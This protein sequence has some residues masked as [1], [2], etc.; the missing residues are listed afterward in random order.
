MKKVYINIG[1]HSVLF[2]LDNMMVMIDN[3]EYPLEIAKN[4]RLIEA[5]NQG[6]V[7]IE[8]MK[9]I[10]YDQCPL[11][12]YAR[13]IFGNK[14][15]KMDILI[16]ATKINTYCSGYLNRSLGHVNDVNEVEL[17]QVLKGEVIELVILDGKAYVGQFK[18]NDFFEIPK[19]AFHCTYVLE[20]N[21]VVA[22]IYNNTFWQE[23]YTKKPYFETIND[24]SFLEIDGIVMLKQYGRPMID[25]NEVFKKN[26]Y[27]RYAQLDFAMTIGKEIKH[28]EDLFSFYE[29]L[30]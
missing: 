16:Y 23:D 3:Y 29:R 15:F 6:R 12:Y 30:V 27:K 19:G 22:N 25:I 11:Y 13:D 9:D 17:H 14:D 18:Q 1:K 4:T 21:T 20:D 8:D 5:I 7:R 28:E 24:I 26:N 10:V 2:D